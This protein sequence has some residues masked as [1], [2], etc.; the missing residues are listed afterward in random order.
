MI[1]GRDGSVAIPH[2]RRMALGCGLIASTFGLP[3]RAWPQGFVDAVESLPV[4]WVA[5]AV[6]AVVAIALALM[7]WRRQEAEYRPDEADAPPL[8]FPA[9]PASQRRAIR[10][11]PPVPNRPSMFAASQAQAAGPPS[12]VHPG[13]QPVPDPVIHS[14]APAGA[15]KI[16]SPDSLV[17]GQTIRFHR[18]IDGTLQ[19]LPGRLDIV[20]GAEEGQTIRF[21]RTGPEVEVTFGRTDGPAYRHIQLR[22]PTVSR[23]HAR[24]RMEGAAWTIANLSRTN[25]VVVNGEELVAEG[26]ARALSE[27]D[28]I[29]MGE[30]AFI[31]HE[32]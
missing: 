3:A 11:A 26:D 2:L 12:A 5:V 6:V 7:F 13:A 27:G 32:R 20:E 18:P 1:T 24:M 25:P 9:S 21:V 19:I 30:I 15:P 23:Q 17:D 4:I 29:E 8:V 31:F 16:A 10:P 28:R 22:A 14:T